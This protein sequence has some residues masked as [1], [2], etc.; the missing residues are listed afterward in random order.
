MDCQRYLCRGVKAPRETNLFSDV[1]LKNQTGDPRRFNCALWLRSLLRQTQLPVGEPEDQSCGR[2]K[3]YSKLVSIAIESR[4]ENFKPR[5]QQ[6]SATQLAVM[7]TIPPTVDA[8]RGH[9]SAG[10]QS[11]EETERAL[12]AL[13]SAGDRCAMDELY[14]LYFA[15]LANFFRNLT[16]RDDFTEELINDTMF[17]VWKEGAATGANASV[18][19]AIMGFAYSRVQKRF[20]QVRA[21]PPHVQPAIIDTDHGS[22]LPTTDMPS[23]PQIFLSKLPAEERAVV[24]LAYASGYSRGDIA[25]IMNISCECVDVLFGDARHRLDHVRGHVGTGNRD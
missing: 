4:F 9:S 21:N 5:I 16:A 7:D 17:E 10:N 23:N 11:T 1:R 6:T 18:S 12:L 14:I 22:P 25:Y 24:H 2:R 8:T 13:V 3:G 19:L 20:A 15:R